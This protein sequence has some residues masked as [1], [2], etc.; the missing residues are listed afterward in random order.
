M[1]VAASGGAVS[2]IADAA[3]GLRIFPHALPDG[4]HYL[5]WS[6]D[7]KGQGRGIYVGSLDSPEAH[8]IAAEDST[9]AYAQGYVS[10]RGST[11]CSPSHST[12]IG[13]SS[14][15]IRGRLADGIGVGV[16]NPFTYAFSVSEAGIVTSWSGSALPNL[17]LTWF[18]RAGQ[19]LGTAGRHPIQAGL[20]L[21]R[22]AR[23][24]ALELPNTAARGI[25]VWLLDL[26]SGAA[27]ARLTSDG[28]F[29]VPVI[30]PDGSRVAM[31]E[32]DRGI[33]ILST[34]TAPRLNWSSPARRRN[35]RSP[36]R[37]TVDFWRSSI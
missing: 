7:I 9:V 12:S 8:R 24:A 14:P 31:M 18:D 17:Q 28:R 11:R 33:V 36:G 19:R 3:R 29:S 27:A 20:T 35:G 4:R 37:P 10:S 15:G 34:A 6:S 13:R 21:D 26:T 32:R 5:F 16:G 30:S 1:R 25:D 22:E 2:T 23:R